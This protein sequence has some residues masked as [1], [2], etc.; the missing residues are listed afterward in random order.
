VAAEQQKLRRLI[1]S[2]LMGEL[3]PFA[4]GLVGARFDHRQIWQAIVEGG[5]RAGLLVAGGTLP[6]LTARARIAGYS[7]F[8]DGLRD[9]GVAALARFAVSEDHAALHVAL[10]R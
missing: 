6:A 5:D 1:P 10:E 7:S 4:H 3:A 2:G 8:Q 9:P